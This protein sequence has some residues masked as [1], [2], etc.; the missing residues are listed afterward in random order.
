MHKSSLKLIKDYF[1]I[2]CYFNF[3]QI[4]LNVFF[5]KLSKN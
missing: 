1:K 2:V 4:K 5:S 3:N